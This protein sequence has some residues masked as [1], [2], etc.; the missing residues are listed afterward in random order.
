MSGNS[1][2]GFADGNMPAQKRRTGGVLWGR[3][4]QFI[5]TDE[6]PISGVNN[7][8]IPDLGKIYPEQP[9]APM[10]TRMAFFVFIPHI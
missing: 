5:G 4:G 8:S 9:L 10:P 3:G 6:L 7:R 2:T 1:S